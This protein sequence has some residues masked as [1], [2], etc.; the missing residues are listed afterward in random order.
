MIPFIPETLR[1]LLIRHLVSVEALGSRRQASAVKHGP[2]FEG[3]NLA[4][5]FGICLGARQPM[6]RCAKTAFDVTFVMGAM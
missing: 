1:G 3:V 4:K 6:S 2:S 5:V